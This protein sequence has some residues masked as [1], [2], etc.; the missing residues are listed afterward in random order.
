M[1]NNDIKKQF[2]KIVAD[3]ILNESINEEI[4]LVGTKNQVEVAKNVILES[5]KLYKTLINKESTLDEVKLQLNKKR[6]AAK[7][8]KEVY[9]YIWP[10]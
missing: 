9:G 1:H 2:L 10:L 7:K 6:L 8:F 5:K 4:E 3:F